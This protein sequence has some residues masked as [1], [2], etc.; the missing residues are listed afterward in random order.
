M[1]KCVSLRLL[2]TPKRPFEYKVPK[3]SKKV[4]ILAQKAK[5]WAYKAPLTPKR[6]LKYQ[7]P[8]NSKKVQCQALEKAKILAFEDPFN[9][10]KASD[11]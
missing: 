5:L 7:V 10:K 9:S 11:A 3:K 1:P 8:K 4:H 2:L 6:P